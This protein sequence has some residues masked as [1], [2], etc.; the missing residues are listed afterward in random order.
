M[1]QGTTVKTVNIFLSKEVQGKFLTGKL[2]IE[3]FKKQR[4][5]YFYP[6]RNFA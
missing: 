1:L 5:N 2:A 3:F 4:G 6:R